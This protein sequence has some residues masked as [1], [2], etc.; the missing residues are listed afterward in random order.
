MKGVETGGMMIPTV[1]FAI[2]MKP[3]KYLEYESFVDLITGKRKKEYKDML[4]RYGL[5]NAKVWYHT[6]GNI[7]YLLTVHDLTPEAEEKLK[8]F[9]TSTHAFD[10]W[11]HDECLKVWDV[12]SFGDLPLQPTF[13][14]EMDA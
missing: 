13:M 2:P 4:R 1:L 12:T 7:P 6:F 14:Y 5:K 3:E 11:F 9:A 10:R 8:G